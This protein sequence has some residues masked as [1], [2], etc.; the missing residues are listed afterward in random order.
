MNQLFQCHCDDCHPKTHL[1]GLVRLW[2]HHKQWKKRA[3]NRM[4][5]VVEKWKSMAFQNLR[6]FAMTIYIY[7]NMTWN[8]ECQTPFNNKIIFEFIQCINHR[9][10]FWH[11]HN[12]IYTIFIKLFFFVV[13]AAIKWRTSRSTIPWNTLHNFLILWIDLYKWKNAGKRAYKRAQTHSHSHTHTLAHKHTRTHAQTLIQY[14]DNI[15]GL[16]FFSVATQSEQ[17]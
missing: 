4:K 2:A 5:N 10:S 16:Q 11:M 1:F 9:P 8:V 7:E 17:F 14:S 3:T 6:M 12:Q 15:S 13:V